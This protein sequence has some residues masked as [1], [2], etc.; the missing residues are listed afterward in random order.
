RTKSIADST[1][2]PTSGRMSLTHSAEA[3]DPRTGPWT[4]TAGMSVGRAGHTATLLASRQGLK[5]R[6][7][8]PT[9]QGAKGVWAWCRYR[10]RRRQT[11]YVAIEVSVFMVAGH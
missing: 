9:S 5:E 11:I 6:R 1:G 7:E 3:Y 4:A 8:D 2:A 10:P